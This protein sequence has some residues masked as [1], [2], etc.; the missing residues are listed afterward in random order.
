MSAA[1]HR[2]ALQ[3]SLLAKIID[4][5][6]IPFSYPFAHGR[7]SSGSEAVV[8]VSNV[9]VELERD[10]FRNSAK[11]GGAVLPAL[12]PP[13]SLREPVVAA[14]DIPLS[15]LPVSEIIYSITI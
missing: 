6:R 10:G 9:T 8:F 2:D 15:G 7:I 4:P 1:V 12:G 3:S 14:F 13:G 5:C 11:D